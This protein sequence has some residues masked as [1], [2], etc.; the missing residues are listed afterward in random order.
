MALAMNERPLRKTVAFG[1]RL[2]MVLM[3][4]LSDA[5][6]GAELRINAINNV[7]DSFHE[8]AAR[9]DKDRYLSLMTEDG[10]FM[11]TDEWERW[12]KHPQFTEFVSG[13]FQGGEGWIYHPVE[14]HVNRAG[15]VAWFDEVVVAVDGARFRGTG[16]LVL[17]QGTWKIAHYALSFIIPNAHWD[18]VIELTRISSAKSGAQSR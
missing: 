5:V 18:A 1:I 4:L 10:V 13:R 7:L 9:G 3:T 15:D 2:F 12:P 16:V 11:G 14:R 6:F 17:E 8:A